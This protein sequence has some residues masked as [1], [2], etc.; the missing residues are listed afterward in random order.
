M[1]ASSASNP[2]GISAG[3]PGVFR[4]WQ[5][6]MG[7]TWTRRPGRGLTAALALEWA[8]PGHGNR[9]QA[10]FHRF[11]GGL[12]AALAVPGSAGDGRSDH[13]R[14]SHALRPLGLGAVLARP[15][16]PVALAASEP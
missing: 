4:L 16:R 8:P 14:R 12:S 1:A 11:P 10:I 6:R 2:A 15:E 13:R 3:Q 5:P 7:A 9:D